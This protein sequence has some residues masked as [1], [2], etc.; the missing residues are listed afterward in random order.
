MNSKPAWMSEWGS[1]SEEKKNQNTNHTK[2]NK[3]QQFP[4]SKRKKKQSFQT[5]EKRFLKIGKTFDGFPVEL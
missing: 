4:Y 2:S 5:F 3:P 1:V